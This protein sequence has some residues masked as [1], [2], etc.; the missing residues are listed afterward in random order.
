LRGV[1]R[2]FLAFR[3][4]LLPAHPKPDLAPTRPA[5]DLVA[6]IA[7]Q[8]E[9]NRAVV[10][11]ANQISQFVLLQRQPAPTSRPPA[12]PI[13][14]RQPELPLGNPGDDVNPWYWPAE[15]A[16]RLNISIREVWGVA[17]QLGLAKQPY[18]Q[19]ARRL[20]G[21]IGEQFHRW[22]ATEIYY[23][24]RDRQKPKQ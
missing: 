11:L 23:A 13:T 6:L 10:Q 18:T 7:A 3:I 2:V 9:T 19:R 21:T 17:R 12:K 4:G 5:V 22:A 8:A 24:V 15:I 20:D 1:V 16:R 14:Q